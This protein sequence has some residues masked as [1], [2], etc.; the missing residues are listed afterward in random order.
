M[1]NA[2]VSTPRSSRPDDPHGF[3]GLDVLAFVSELVLWTACGIAANRLAG[4][5]TAGLVAA[6]VTVL[7]VIIGWSVVMAPRA[8]RRLRVK[9]RHLVVLALGGV[10]TVLL[11]TSAAPVWAGAAA[12]STLVL[13]V[14]DRTR[15][16]SRAPD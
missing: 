12:L 7:A 1:Q 11:A 16:T 6:V 15:R 8:A 5:G 10:A 2:G 3:D 9:G 14:A 13:I 4:G